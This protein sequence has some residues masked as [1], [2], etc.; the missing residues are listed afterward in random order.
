MKDLTPLLPKIEIEPLMP[1]TAGP[2]V[3]W[4]NDVPWSSTFRSMEVGQSFLCPS[5]RL[6]QAKNRARDLNAK[7][8]TRQVD[9]LYHRVW[10]SQRPNR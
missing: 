8:V 3:I 7:V 5:D 4:P 6:K 1:G 10:L 2:S 9:G